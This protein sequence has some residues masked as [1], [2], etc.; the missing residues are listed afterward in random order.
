MRIFIILVILLDIVFCSIIIPLENADTK[1]ISNVIVDSSGLLDHIYK[2]SPVIY[3]INGDGIKDLAY[4]TVY[5]HSYNSYLSF[6]FGK[7]QWP[8]ILAEDD[9]DIIVYDTFS[10]YYLDLSCSAVFN[11]SLMVVKLMPAP[12]VPDEEKYILFPFNLGSGE[13]LIDDIKI[14]VL[15]NPSEFGVGAIVAPT[16]ARN[17]VVYDSF[18]IAF[19]L[20]AAPFDRRRYN[21]LLFI[22]L[23]IDS[24]TI[25]IFSSTY[26]KAFYITRRR[27]FLSGG[28]HFIYNP[29]DIND[30]GYFDVILL[31]N[32]FIIG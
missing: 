32:F 27:I 24:D 12:A 16:L 29:G 28:E 18:L 13:Y 2:Y 31:Q 9:A 7:Q 5:W 17:Y 6:F 8:H 20:Y 30:D 14:K 1:I 15:I 19:G 22:P 3:D 21:V 10:N 11:D 4:I 23:N 26:Y 25:D